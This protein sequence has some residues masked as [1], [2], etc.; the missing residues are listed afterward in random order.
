MKRDGVID[1]GLQVSY[2]PDSRIGASLKRERALDAF[3]D[4]QYFPDSRIGASL[5]RR[6]RDAGRRQ[7]LGLPRFANRGLIEAMSRPQAR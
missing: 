7:G 3:R 6:V 2:F 1:G 5:K 4:D